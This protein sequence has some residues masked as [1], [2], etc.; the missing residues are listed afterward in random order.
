MIHK[1]GNVRKDQKCID[2][3]EIAPRIQVFEWY[4][5]ALRPGAPIVL[6]T[7]TAKQSSGKARKGKATCKQTAVRVE[8]IQS[9]EM[10]GEKVPQ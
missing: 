2:G 7:Q 1:D 3:R 4:E 9:P 8:P 6:K 10:L 5:H